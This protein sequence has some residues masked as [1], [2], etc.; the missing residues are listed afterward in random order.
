MKPDVIVAW[1]K[2]LDY[3]LWRKFIKE[4]RHRFDKVI[5]IFTD[6]N[7]DGD[8]R[9][10]VKYKMGDGIIFKTS[11]PASAD[12]D[13]RDK[14]VNMALEYSIL[15]WV[16]FTEQ[17]FIIHDNDK[18]WGIVNNFYQRGFK[19][20]GYYQGGVRLHPSCLFVEWET[21]RQT[22]MDFGVVPDKHD[23]FYKI[24]QDLKNVNTGFMV[25]DESFTH[26]NGLSQN[27]HMLQHGEEP[28]Y[29]PA[30]FLKYTKDCLK[31]DM[32]PD[33][34]KLFEDYGHV[35]TS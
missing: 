6:M 22:R 11:T 25:E 33:F 9:D 20:I 28:N 14:A 3:P 31:E 30:E 10:F 12:Q 16:W 29:R 17:D 35:P 1:P 13:W 23:H 34:I 27:I 2:H 32:H 4:Q 26:M 8:Y 7:T 19:A 21:L 5:I 18:F 24:A 15:N